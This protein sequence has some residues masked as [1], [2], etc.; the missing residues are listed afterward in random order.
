MPY[1]LNH[2][3]KRAGL[4]LL[5]AWLA[6]SMAGAAA[7][8][9]QARLYCLSLR[10][11]QG[12]DQQ[13]GLYTL[14]LSTVDPPGSPNGELA[15]DYFGFTS[16]YSGFRLYDGA[17]D[18][19]IEGEIDIDAPLSKDVNQNGFADFF[20]VSQS[21]SGT[22]TGLLSIP[23]LGDS[24]TVKATWSRAA[25]SKDG[26]CTLQLTSRQFGQLP[27]FAHT[28][29]LI[30]YAGGL[31]YTPGTNRVTGTVDLRQTGDPQNRLVG[32]VEF[33]KSGADPYNQ[34]ELQAGT[35][36]NA[37]SEQM[38]FLT[39]SYSREAKWPTNY[40]G[41]L[42]FDDGDLSTPELDYYDWGLSIDDLND[43]DKDGIPDFS[44][45]P[46][47]VPPRTPTLGLAL[48]GS[49][50]TFTIRGTVGRTHEL[51]EATSLVLK[52]WKTVKS[53]VL[54]SDPETVTLPPP[55]EGVRYW[56]MRVP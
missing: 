23:L 25:G 40:F 48:N 51:Q 24:G 6:T 27:T 46:G 42:E 30:E 49:S 21:V 18:E 22:T 3:S 29:E 7:E 45:D 1:P 11:Q 47:V 28:F 9:A 5:A 36:T 43:G 38:T 34:L 37:L 17:L 31:S 50:L 15:P 20:E 2:L 44:D 55:T 56:R 53:L 52:D 16:H 19:T 10:F 4:L 14:D 35:W 33:V 41:Y 13:S 8:L 39:D 12:T 54:A 32:P 26:T